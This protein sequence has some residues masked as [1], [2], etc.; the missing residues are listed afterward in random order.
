MNLQSAHKDNIRAPVR[1]VVRN[2]PADFQFVMNVDGN[3]Y[4]NPSMTG[5]R[6]IL[7]ENSGTR[8]RG[9]KGSIGISDILQV[10]LYYVFH[11]LRT[12]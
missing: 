8:L 2:L 9:M 10:E 5:F 7:R 3:S 12:V 1:E 6:A 11:G 4:G